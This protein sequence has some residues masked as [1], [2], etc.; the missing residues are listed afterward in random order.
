METGI[1]G[2]Y[3]YPKDFA[4]KEQI[5]NLIDQYNLEH[6]TDILPTDLTETI[7]SNVEMLLDIIMPVL[8]VLSS[9]SIVVAMILTASILY[10]NVLERTKEIGLFRA[11]GASKKD[12]GRVFRLMSLF[13]GLFSGFIGIGLTYIGQIVINAVL[14]SLMPN[15]QISSLFSLP[16]WLAFVL[17]AFALILSYLASLIP[18]YI[19]SKKDPILAL[20]EE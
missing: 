10:S 16:V 3:L 6:Q 17:L 9:V 20:K 18:S 14:S 5:L 1:T 4:S 7:F 12:V 19:A 13:I 15:Y 2:F 8:I 11:L